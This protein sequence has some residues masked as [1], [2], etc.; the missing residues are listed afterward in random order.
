M[1]QLFGDSFGNYLLH[2][3]EEIVLPAPVSWWPHTLGWK[4]LA[5]ALALVLARLLYVR[6][7]RWQRDRYRRVALAELGTIE[8]AAHT[9][10]DS[11]LVHLPKLLKGAALHA[12]PRIDIAS[13]SGTAWLAFL[14]AHYT[15]PSFQQGAGRKLLVI[16]YQPQQQWQLSTSEKQQ[17]ISQ[18]RRWLA[19]HRATPT[20]A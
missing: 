7:L 18:C 14:D 17:L 6:L 11:A 12:F 10:G 2:G 4:L 16:A 3:M 15:G 8:Q 9:Q 1:N 5:L 13:L 20:H 19:K